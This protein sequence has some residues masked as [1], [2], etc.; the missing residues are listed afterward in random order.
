MFY[1]CFSVPSL[2]SWTSLQTK[3][4]LTQIS[5]EPTKKPV[6]CDRNPPGPL[7]QEQTE[8]AKLH[9]HEIVV[10]GDSRVK[11][12]LS[13]VTL[14]NRI[15]NPA[16]ERSPVVEGEAKCALIKTASDAKNEANSRQVLKMNKVGIDS[17]VSQSKHS[18]DDAFKDQGKHG[19]CLQTVSKSKIPKRLIPGDDVA[20]TACDTSLTDASGRVAMKAQKQTC[21]KESSKTE[22]KVDKKHMTE[23]KEDLSDIGGVGKQED[24]IKTAQSMEK[25]SKYPLNSARDREDGRASLALKSANISCLTGKN[26]DITTINETNR[27]SKTSK[28]NLESEQQ[29]SPKKETL[30]QG[31]KHSKTGKLLATLNWE[32]MLNMKEISHLVVKFSILYRCT[33]RMHDRCRTVV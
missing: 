30:A 1:N 6:E 28:I 33:Y 9:G 7:N 17:D 27:P 25:H 29:Q 10:G 15:S 4:K 5:C 23:R 16:V 32:Q 13:K 3:G 22:N 18:N 26:C 8:I 19:P 31:P 2:F 12:Q 24:S 14:S 20:V 21:T 11:G